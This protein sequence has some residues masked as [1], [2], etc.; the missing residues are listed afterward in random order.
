MPPEL[1]DAGIELI[2]YLSQF[3]GP[4][5]NA[6][7]LA[8]SGI[9]S[10]VGYL[11]LVCI[12]WWRFSWKLGAKLFVALVL[13]VYLNAVIKD[14]VAQP[15]PFI[16]ADIESVT[17][18][19]EFG[20]PSGHAQH[21]ALV[22]SLLAAHFRKRWI[23][24]LAAGM[25]LLIGFSRVHLGVHFPTDVLGGW[26]LGGILAQVY[27]RW[28]DP[29]I[30]WAR[31]LS[32]ERQMF[33]AL[34]APLVLTLFH[35]TQN[36]AT[37]LGALAGALGGLALARRER[38]YSDDEPGRT[39]RKQLL[40]GLIGL[41]VLYLALIILSPSETSRLYYVYVWMRFAAIGLWA[42]YL[43]PKLTAVFRTKH[44]NLDASEAR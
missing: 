26:L 37:A 13:S 27:L 10:T 25:V 17:R 43:V 22:W 39:R 31:R 41:P 7:F 1:L 33:L 18:P 38:L 44:E 14:W 34:G 12:L 6:F 30:D 4:W 23:T 42:S 9:G 16:Y 28:S 36:T 11:V 3:R 19:G 29:A 24:V 2:R 15:R 40:V 32:F 21:A 5:V 20:F 8:F 35:G